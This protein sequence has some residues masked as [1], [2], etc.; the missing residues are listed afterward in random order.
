MDNAKI[1]ELENRKAMA[2]EQLK[3]RVALAQLSAQRA[4]V[5]SQR[6]SATKLASDMLKI[7]SNARQSMEQ[8]HKQNQPHKQEGKL[9]G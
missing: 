2:E 8:A 3:A 6:A 5:Q 1:A 4:E 9:N 7:E